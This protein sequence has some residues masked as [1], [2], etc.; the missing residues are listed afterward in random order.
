[1]RRN[2]LLLLVI[3][4]AS[5]L[6]LNCQT[7]AVRA[8]KAGPCKFLS[9]AEAEKILGRPVELVTNSWNFTADITRFDCT[10]RALERE[11][12]SGR[13]I[14]LYFMIEEASDETAAR[15]IYA[16][17]WNSNRNHRGIEVLS[18]IGDEAYR[19]SDN[20]NFHFVMA[21][22][23]K[24]TIRLKINK[25]SETTSPEELKAFIKRV[26]EEI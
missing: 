13:E 8:E 18:G 25:T 17:I 7:K 23:G 2:I 5:V 3:F 20:A 24:F 22:K 21:R 16:D 14:D 4:S 10:Y 19:H 11:K 6:T 9:F 15:R 1:M 26:T 12:T